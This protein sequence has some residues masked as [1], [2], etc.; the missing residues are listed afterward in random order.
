MAQQTSQDIDSDLL[1]WL[2]DGRGH[3]DQT[4]ASSNTEEGFVVGEVIPGLFH[5]IYT[6]M[7]E[8]K[9]R[10]TLLVQSP[11]RRRACSRLT[12]LPVLG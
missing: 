2:Q 11:Y 6:S 1:V 5:G 7:C 4:K 12:S 10:A 3:L 8:G 9:N